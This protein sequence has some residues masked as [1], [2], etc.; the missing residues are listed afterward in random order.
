M[1]VAAWTNPS[2]YFRRSVRLFNAEDLQT[3]GAPRANLSTTLGITI[4]SENMVYTWGNYNTTGINVAPA[5]GTSSLNDAAETSHYMP[6]LPPRPTGADL[7]RRGCLVPVVQDLV[8]Q[9]ELHVS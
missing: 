1:T 2:N 6:D 9:F 7:D 4:S 3:T 5:A 8:R